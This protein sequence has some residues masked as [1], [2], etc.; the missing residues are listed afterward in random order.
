VDL[1]IHCVGVLFFE[2]ILPFRIFQY[3][4][5]LELLLIGLLLEAMSLGLRK[6]LK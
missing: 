6:C 5:S 4:A 2:H 1:I 3:F